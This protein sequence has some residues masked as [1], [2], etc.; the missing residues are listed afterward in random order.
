M[1]GKKYSFIERLEYAQMNELT[2]MPSSASNSKASTQKGS[3]PLTLSGMGRWK[4]KRYL[5][6]SSRSRM[7]L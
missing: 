1:S 5:C 6:T 3:V 7:M 2:S 4:M